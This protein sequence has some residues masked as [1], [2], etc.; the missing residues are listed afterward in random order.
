M[1][2]TAAIERYLRT[3]D[4]DPRFFGWPGDVIERERQAHHALKRALVDEVSRR[5]A[6]RRPSAEM[7]AI[8]ITAGTR[9]KV[10]PMVRGLF[11]EMAHEVM[12][13]D[14]AR[15]RNGRKHILARCAPRRE[16]RASSSKA[17]SGT[18]RSEGQ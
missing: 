14:A 1:S 15:A 9:A 16:R 3:G 12:L 2:A 13:R 5:A 17:R 8:D 7:P 6:G 11:P 18:M 4:H 10:E